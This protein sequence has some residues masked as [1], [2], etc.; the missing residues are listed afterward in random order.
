FRKNLTEK[1][2]VAVARRIHKRK[3]DDKETKIMLDG[4]P[5][6][7]KKVQKAISRYGEETREPTWNKMKRK[8]ESGMSFVLV[9][10]GNA[11]PIQ[12][13]SPCGQTPQGVMVYTPPSMSQDTPRSSTAQLL[14]FSSLP[15]F[16]FQ[17]LSEFRGILSALIGLLAMILTF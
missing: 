1:E 13:E 9:S 15:W 14:G 8:Q 17:E 3:R 7:T 6:S 5:M 2:W 12:G 4:I 16:R 10:Q 11:N